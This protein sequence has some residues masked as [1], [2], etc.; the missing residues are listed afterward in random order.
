M[1]RL[2]CCTLVALFCATTIYAQVETFKANPKPLDDITERSAVKDRM[3]LK[4]APIREADIMWEKRIWREIDTREKMNLSFRYPEMPL[5]SVLKKGI[6]EGAIVAYSGD[7]DKFTTPMQTEDLA[8]QF[9]TKDTVEVIDPVTELPVFKE[10]E[11]EINPMA[12][13]RF[14]VKEVWYMDNKY[15]T[16]KVRILGIAP[17][18]EEYDK[19]GNFL[20]EYP[21]FWIYYPHAREYLAQNEVFNPWNDAANM[22]WDDL[23][24]MR[25]FASYITKESNIHDRRLQDYLSGRNLLLESQKIKEE[26]FNK[27]QDLWSY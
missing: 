17:I 8:L 26:I 14:R 4:Y 16:M 13:K 15:S 19:N 6:D 11:S 5:F 21:L 10:V 23:F 12:I 27:E 1:N 25:F 18:Y 24:E 2:I 9:Y 3:V 22:S 7:D 20:Y